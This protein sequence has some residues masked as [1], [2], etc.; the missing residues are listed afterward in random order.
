LPEDE[1]RKCALSVFKCGLIGILIEKFVLFNGSGR[2]GKGLLLAYF[3]S[4]MGKYCS[5]ADVVLITQNKKASAGSANPAL[6]VLEFKRCCIMSEPEEDELINTGMMKLLT[7]NKTFLTRG[8]YQSAREITNSLI[9]ILECNSRPEFKGR[10]DNALLSR[11]VD[12]LF[13]QEFGNDEERI[14][15]DE[16]YHKVD[17]TLKDEMMVSQH[18]TAFFHILLQIE[19][20]EV[21]EPA[22]VKDRGKEFLLDTDALVTWVK[23]T[24]EYVDDRKQIIKMKDLYDA[25][26][27]SE[28]YYQ[29][30]NKE[31]RKWGKGKFVENLRN[32]IQ[33][34]KYCDIDCRNT[35]FF[36]NHKLKN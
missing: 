11:L 32:N 5:D 1:V 2:N 7:G 14:K 31:K 13:T 33:L 28:Y 6:A 20:F 18:A 30:D 35:Q 9:T 26:K 24:F 17:P 15:K 12:I 22:T 29:L 21:Y 3:K 36:T 19:G 25:F 27:M 23:E 4:L 16:N 8:L 34:R 10:K